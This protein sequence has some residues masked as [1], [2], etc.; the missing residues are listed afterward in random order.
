MKTIY[1]EDHYKHQGKYELI[2]GEFLPPFENVKRVEII[3]ERI[4][5]TNM[6]EIIFPKDFGLEPIKRVHTERYVNF[7]QT[8]HDEWRKVRGD[9]DALPL[10]WPNRGLRMIEPESIDGKLG[11]YS[12]DAGTPI[13]KTSWGAMVSS[14]NV[15]LTGAEHIVQGTKTIFSL[16]RPP[17]HHAD[18]EHFGGYCF[19]NNAAIAAQYLLDKGL[20]KVAILDVD[21]HHGNGT[22][23]I[24]YDRADVL[25]V[26]LHGHPHQEY[27]HFLGYEDE[28]GEGKGK[29]YNFN[30]PM[31]FG[32]AWDVFGQA[33]KAGIKNVC[34]YTPD[35]LVVS[36]GVD[37]Y[38]K[39][40]ISHFRL[41][42]EDFTAMGK[43]IAGLKLPTLF[44]M[45]GGYAV[46]EIGVN[47]VNTL[48]GFEEN[49]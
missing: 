31:R 33:L 6:G 35:V 9:H 48:L 21:Y 25:F 1:S 10:V 44:V 12:Y 39:D 42:H 26:S 20:S 32:T 30:Y 22:Q 38:K 49:I 46:E 19:F 27:P 23:S 4:K 8:A 7:L 24:F 5:S 17:G 45:E 29:G 41:E 2:N 47:V 37:T 14:V 3:L 13:T 36:L 43:M 16:C 11:Y 28:H 18:A 34:D 15:A 40:P